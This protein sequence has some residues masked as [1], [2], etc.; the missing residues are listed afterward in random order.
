MAFTN[1]IKAQ[2][3]SKSFTYLNLMETQCSG[4]YECHILHKETETERLGSFPRVTQLAVHGRAGCCPS[5]LAPRALVLT[6]GVFFLFM[7]HHM[8]FGSQGTRWRSA[9]RNR[10]EQTHSQ[11]S[12]SPNPFHATF[13]SHT[14]VS[15]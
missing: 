15:P 13:R 11:F 9:D 10:W 14:Q 5:R 12:L 2:A 6:T 7:C 1:T 8:A 4:Y 3:C